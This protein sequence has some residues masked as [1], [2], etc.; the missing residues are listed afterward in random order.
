MAL[1]QMIL[2][3]MRILAY[4]LWA[5]K[6]LS[7]VLVWVWEFVIVILYMGGKPV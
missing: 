7:D 1:L 5:L 4:W 2:L 6:T 3:A